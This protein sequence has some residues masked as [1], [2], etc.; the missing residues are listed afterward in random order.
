MDAE[1]TVLQGQDSAG[2]SGEESAYNKQE[3]HLCCN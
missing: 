2:V 1:E 3:K